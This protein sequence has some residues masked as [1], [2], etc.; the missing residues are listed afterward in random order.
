M[1]GLIANYYGAEIGMGGSCAAAAAEKEDGEVGNSHLHTSNVVH[2]SPSPGSSI[3]WLV[4]GG[5]ETAR[6]AAAAVRLRS[7]LFAFF[8]ERSIQSAA[9]V[10][11]R[12]SHDQ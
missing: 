11:V 7:L 5:I 1:D 10:I 4:I 6:C 9:S 12:R 8:N 2:G 3:N